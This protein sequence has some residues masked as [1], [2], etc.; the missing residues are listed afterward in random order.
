MSGAIGLEQLKKLPRFIEMRRKNAE[1]LLISFKR[2][3]KLRSK[4]KLVD[5]AHLHFP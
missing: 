5:L 4:K 3:K 1:H 2:K